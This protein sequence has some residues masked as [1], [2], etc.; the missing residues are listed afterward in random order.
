MNKSQVN[1][2]ARIQKAALSRVPSADGRIKRLRLVEI[3]SKT[4]MVICEA[5]TKDDE[6][7]LAKVFCRARGTFMVGP[8]GGIKALDHAR[9]ATKQDAK[10]SP[11][12][13]GWR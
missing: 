9:H 12:I 4:L 6:G 3:S 2:V 10:R 5:G 13:F 1:A 11:L 7:T 8:R